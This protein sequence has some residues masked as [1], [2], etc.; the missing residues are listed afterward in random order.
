[1]NL[2]NIK[3]IEF[4]N[5]EYQGA[6][7]KIIIAITLESICIVLLLVLAIYSAQKAGNISI[8]SEIGIYI[9]YL[10]ICIM[11]IFCKIY[12]LNK[13]TTITEDVVSK[14]RVRLTDKLRHTELEFI[15]QADKGN[16]YARI[17]QDTEII[18]QASPNIMNTFESAI[19][20]GAVF[21][22]MSSISML[23]FGIALFSIISTY[24]AFFFNYSK[25]KE[26]L[27]KVRDK[28]AKFSI[29]LNELL[30]GFKE[31]KIN[32]K[33]NNAL[34][35][36]IEMLAEEMEQMHLF[37]KIKF[38]ENIVLTMI[39][40]LFAIAIV[41]FLVPLFSSTS[42]EIITELVTCLLFIMGLSGIA[43]RG[44]FIHLQ[45]N[46]AIENLEKLEQMITV[47]KISP[48]L[49]NEHH[50]NDFKEISL[51]S[52]YFQYKDQHRKVLF[53]LSP[54]NLTIKQGDIIFIVGENGSGKS[55]FVKLLTG[56]YLPTK[57]V[58]KI[59]DIEID[60][61]N[62][63]SYR[64]LF[65]I[66]F[67]DFHLFK[68]LYG[69]EP[70]E[71]EKVQKYLKMMQM[72]EKTHYTNGSFTN[73]QLSSGEKKRLA[74]ITAILEDKPVFVFDG[75]AADQDPYFKKYFY[76]VLL[77]NLKAMGKTVITVTHNDQY[78]HLAERVIKIEKGKISY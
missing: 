7:G 18:S 11:A 21:L 46:V 57:G 34:F 1:M 35:S 15:E 9:F 63:Q 6:K 69:L 22:Y 4:F 55:T 40:Q 36:D 65:S 61:D 72:Q 56:L 3:I 38:D 53:A 49:D 70:M 24:S 29:L 13:A 52:T 67:T 74:Y 30:T 39:L 8:G 45:A 43:L 31:I 47:S 76:E 68:K 50:F 54:I 26:E 48:L 71:K 32:T 28:E 19:A 42:N 20:A 25:I 60:T 14:V 23:G 12:A 16:I 5:S 75:W 78:F 27:R 64:E 66:I 41:I 10:L 37:A 2:K 62:Y 17:T 77:Q 44:T 59:D 58:I 51:H 33:K 73:I